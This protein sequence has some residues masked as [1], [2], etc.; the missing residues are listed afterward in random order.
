MA[1]NEG[2]ARALGIDIHI[3]QSCRLREEVE[4]YQ[5]LLAGGTRGW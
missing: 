1:S 5:A 2:V 3:L 4:G